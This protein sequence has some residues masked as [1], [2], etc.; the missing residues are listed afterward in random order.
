MVKMLYFKNDNCS[1]CTALLP[2]INRI[3]TNFPVLLET[4]NVTENP[5]LAGQHLVFT[6]PVL[7]ITDVEGKE[8]KRF[9]RHFS[10]YEVTSFLERILP[11]NLA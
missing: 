5:L 2:K 3:A 9:V 7:I 8:L 10:E 4:I 11:T 1:V 6:V